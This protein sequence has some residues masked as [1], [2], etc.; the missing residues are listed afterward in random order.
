MN[1][2]KIAVEI[3]DKIKSLAEEVKGLYDLGYIINITGIG[4]PTVLLKD[5]GFDAL[6]PLGAE[7]EMKEGSDGTPYEVREIE[8]DGVRWINWRKTDVQM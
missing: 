3:Y 1:E 5:A 4:T 8:A 6:F 7:P 2:T